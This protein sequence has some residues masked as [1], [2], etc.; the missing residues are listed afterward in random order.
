M[1]AGEEDNA[2]S[3]KDDRYHDKGCVGHQKHFITKR[4]HCTHAKL[5]NGD[6]IHTIDK[7][8]I[9]TDTKKRFMQ[10][11]LTLLIWKKGVIVM[12]R[13]IGFANPTLLGLMNPCS[14]DFYRCNI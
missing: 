10:F 7:D 13:V 12:Q 4:V 1:H 6:V 9:M 3:L 11:N 14:V 2:P 8:V 5:N